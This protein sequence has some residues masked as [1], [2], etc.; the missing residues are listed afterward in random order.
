VK[1]DGS[2]ANAKILRGLGKSYDEE[3]LRVINLMPKWFPGKQNGQAEDVLFNMPV[4][5]TKK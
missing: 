1:A 5:F 3:V 4:K 2:I